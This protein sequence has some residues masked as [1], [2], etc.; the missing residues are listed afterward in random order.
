[1]APADPKIQALLDDM[2][3]TLDLELTAIDHDATP[4][5]ILVLAQSGPHICGFITP[6]EM[7]DAAQLL[8]AMAAQA[9]KMPPLRLPQR[10][11]RSSSR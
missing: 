10:A 9:R 8:S 5:L 7:E 11:G 4:Y 1:M 3:D 2:A 6:E